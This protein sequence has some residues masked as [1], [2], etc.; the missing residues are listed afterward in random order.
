MKSKQKSR[1]R[2][3]LSGRRTKSRRVIK[4]KRRIKPRTKSRRV[5]KSKRRT[6]PR[7][8][9]RRVINSKRRTKPRTKS[10]RVIKSKRK[11]TSR[12]VIK[13]KSKRR[14]KRSKRR[15]ICKY[16]AGGEKRKAEDDSESRT[17]RKSKS[18]IRKK[19][20]YTYIDGVI[21]KRKRGDDTEEIKSKKIKEDIGLHISFDKTISS[22]SGPIYMSILKPKDETIINFQELYPPIYSPIFILFGDHHY[23]SNYQCDCV[24]RSSCLPNLYKFAE[25]L[26]SMS[27]K[28]YPIDFYVEYFKTLE[29]TSAINEHDDPISKVINKAIDCGGNPIGFTE[30]VS[31]KNDCIYVNNIRWHFADTRKN[32]KGKHKIE[33]FINEF[34]EY[35]SDISEYLEI[36]THGITD[37]TLKVPPKFKTFTQEFI[38]KF[39]IPG[40]HD[41]HY[42]EIINY[43]Q[44][45]STILSNDFFN[46]MKNNSLMIKEFFKLSHSLKFNNFEKIIIEDMSYI[47]NNI[48]KKT[49]VTIEDMNSFIKTL[50]NTY[51]SYFKYLKDEPSIM[52]DQDILISVL[53]SGLVKQIPGYN[54]NKMEVETQKYFLNIKNLIE[55]NIDKLNI[56]I[57]IL[58]KLSVSIMD[59]Y[60][61]A[62]SFK[63]P[64]NKETH[65]YENNSILNISYF[66]TKHSKHILDLLVNKFKLY[67]IVLCQ[68]NHG[69]NGHNIDYNSCIT[70]VLGSYINES[71]I[72]NDK[73]RCIQIDKDIK[74]SDM[75][76]ELKN[77]IKKAEKK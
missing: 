47:V 43:L 77:K 22:I 72:T 39:A 46:N 10:R 74:L 56:L 67:D 26:N 24:D 76:K 13:Y 69:L 11:T 44:I 20:K 60:F 61:I 41:N 75:L 31:E 59:Y 63:K 25:D 1:R 4:S 14:S 53:G 54:I 42:Y 30:R 73:Y 28:E 23:S 70:P 36:K 49:G 66:G 38:N 6:K 35:L 15:N 51:I 32:I 19:N 8:K 2:N 57:T 34:E 12:R 21:K 7:T 17:K 3:Y 68:E 45:I 48:I 40:N 71:D 58:I 37:I 27:T 64:F 65:M 18:K 55:N 52:R 62:R 50:V 33:Y 16:D 29:H 5:I 9:S